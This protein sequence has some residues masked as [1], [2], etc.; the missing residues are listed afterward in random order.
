MGILSRDS[1]SAE[2][3]SPLLNTP[4]ASQSFKRRITLDDFRRDNPKA[5]A[6]PAPIPAAPIQSPP[7]S[8]PAPT[9]AAP[10]PAPA[11]TQR[12]LAHSPPDA[13]P[14]TR[15]F[16]PIPPEV[17][18]L[19]KHPERFAVDVT[20]SSDVA[21]AWMR[22]CVAELTDSIQSQLSQH[23]P[24][25]DEC[26]ILRRMVNVLHAGRNFSRLH[27]DGKYA[28]MNGPA[29]I[30]HANMKRAEAIKR[31]DSLKG[32]RYL[33][34]YAYNNARAACRVWRTICLRLRNLSNE[35]RKREYERTESKRRE[36]QKI[37]KR[38]L[39]LCIRDVDQ[40]IANL[41]ISLRSAKRTGKRRMKGI[42]KSVEP[43]GLPVSDK[44]PINVGDL[45]Y[46][47]KSKVT[48][49]VRTQAGAD[50]ATDLAIDGQVLL[51]NR[52]PE[53]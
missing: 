51:V 37:K 53:A 12:K 16:K 41:T 34:N 4:A 26:D 21:N 36:L 1:R 18:L 33:R 20:A 47:R 7:V 35:H 52:K 49:N 43:V 22:Q 17:A 14:R 2:W 5:P 42:D 25:A 45:V 31:L 10:A 13:K 38:L 44:E 15:R 11:N 29:L 9:P 30:R 28:S 27:T 46:V 40:E 48:F 50:V 8:P 6:A 39:A 3:K 19:I 23:N 24:A 32:L